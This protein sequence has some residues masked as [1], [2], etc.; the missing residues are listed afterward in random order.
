MVDSP[1]ALVDD[2]IYF[3]GG[4]VPDS[5]RT[6][7]ISNQILLLNLSESFYVDNPPWIN[8]SSFPYGISSAATAV[9]NFESIFL[10][11]GIK[12]NLTTHLVNDTTSLLYKFNTIPTSI[13]APVVSGTQP[14]NR[15]ASTM[16]FVKSIGKLWIFGGRQDIL[17]GLN[18]T[19]F[20]DVALFNP[21]LLSWDLRGSLPDS[22]KPRAHHTATLL[23]NGII[24][25]LGGVEEQNETVPIDINLQATGSLVEPRSSHTAVLTDDD[26]IIIYGGW[27]T[28]RENNTTP[29]PL[30]AILDTS[31]YTWSSPKI[32]GDSPPLQSHVAHLYANYLILAFGNITNVNG[33]PTDTT[34]KIYLLDIKN[35]TWEL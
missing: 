9:G 25:I 20:N 16:I 12:E 4:R 17:M 13:V 22:P 29:T 21:D 2:K 14:Q 27:K 11:G 7:R 6:F 15:R 33:P 18:F 28:W 26:K 31:T 3:I 8:V 10:F 5:S 24:V 35:F 19:L 34:N 1:S 30:I 23:K 32:T